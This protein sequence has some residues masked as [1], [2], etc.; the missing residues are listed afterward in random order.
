[1]SGVRIPL[2]PCARVP[3]GAG[4][5]PASG[6][7]PTEVFRNECSPT[8]PLA[9]RHRGA[10]DVP[11]RAAGIEPAGASPWPTIRPASCVANPYRSIGRLRCGGPGG[12][13]MRKRPKATPTSASRSS[14]GADERGGPQYAYPDDAVL[15]PTRGR[16]PRHVA[17][18]PR[19]RRH[20]DHGRGPRRSL[21]RSRTRAI[22][23]N[24]RAG[25]S[26]HADSTPNQTF[27]EFGKPLADALGS[28]S[29]RWTTRR[30][31]GRLQT[32]P[33]PPRATD[34]A[35]KALKDAAQPR[36]GRVLSRGDLAG[37]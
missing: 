23:M 14:A 17:A 2:R 5:R 24:H 28:P 32:G 4:A 13:G 8:Y 34:A 31:A 1:M 3:I 36:A 35:A 9:G 33:T 37:A 25:H 22:G 26:V 11:C 18:G 15:P 12:R 10:G 19:H 29:K 20:F 30:S 16:G 7:H 6:G 27:E 21:L